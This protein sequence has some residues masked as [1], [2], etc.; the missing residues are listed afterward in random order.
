VARILLIDD[1]ADLT[2]F[3]RGELERSGHLVDCL[4]RP[5]QGPEL[6]ART[7]FDLVLLDN[8]MPGMTGIE[9]LGALRDR[10]IEV[11]VI[12]MT[13]Y[14]NPETAIRALAL[15]FAYVIKKDY[16]PFFR[17][18]L[19]VIEQAL[20]ITRPKEVRL[21][22][23]GQP[24]PAGGPKKLVGISGAMLK[25]YT[26]IGQFADRT[27]PVLILGET[28]TGKE[29]VA[30]AFHTY[31]SRK[32]KRFVALCCTALPEALLESELFGHEKG[33]FTG[34]D[35]VNKG[36]IEHASGG[37]LFLDEIG[38]M[39]LALQSKILRVLQEQEIRRVGGTETIKVDV[40]I[41]SATNRDLTAAIAAGSFR[42][43]LFYRLNR[44]TVPLP[45]LRERLEDLPELVDYFLAREA[46]AGNR[47]RP[48]VAEETLDRLRAH[49][50]RGNVRELE[51]V[52]CHALLVCRGSQILSSHLDLP[53]DGD[54]AAPAPDSE[55]EAVTGLRR[56]VEWALASGREGLWPLLHD[57]LER[58]L[59]RAALE[60]SG[61]S[62][63]QVAKVLDM[64]PNTV[65]K[66]VEKY[67]LKSE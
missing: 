1:D 29:L 60:R 52:V 33:A 16:K 14:A 13:G 12:L 24:G 8:V 15:A 38:D 10:G 6:L 63:R 17:D 66:R 19:P 62:K 64:A 53:A 67:G 7:P 42:E 4:D 44:V 32:G 55:E 26:A 51:N 27:D 59:L 11:P 43:D 45:P 50:W 23:E 30:Q 31:S 28:G 22:G 2:R 41:L 49:R 46:E 40:R 34:A 56:A 36:L 21:P 5:Q 20:A 3:L 9:F 25:V 54:R 18:L 39:P 65:I 47:A 35:K 61:G 48:G 37:T 58:E 57:L